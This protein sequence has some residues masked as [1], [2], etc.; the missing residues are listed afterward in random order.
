MCMAAVGLFAGMAGAVMQSMGAKAQADAQAAEYKARA[1]YNKRQAQVER[2][3]GAYESGRLK[4]RG[5]RV[6]SAQKAAFSDSGV[7]LEGT[8]VDVV[9]DSVQQNELD[10][11]AVMWG[12]TLA[13]QNYD[14]ES[15]IN[16]MNRKSAKQAGF[17][18]SLAPLLSGF[19]S[20]QGAFS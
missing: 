14:Y 3:K 6:Y 7:T 2:I 15:K 5:E 17:Y 4:E 16:E 9:S 13:G 8:P 12:Q 19:S 1:L 20:L 10:V 18:A 11:Q